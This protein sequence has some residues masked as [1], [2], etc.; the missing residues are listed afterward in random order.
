MN[1]LNKDQFIIILFR[2]KFTNGNY[3]TLTNLQK[4]NNSQEC[5]NDLL[6]LYQNTLDIKSEEYNSNE[7]I[8]IIFSY[9]II[10]QDKLINNKTKIDVKIKQMKVNNYKLYGYNLPTTMDYN[11]WGTITKKYDNII[12]IL[13]KIIVIYYI[14]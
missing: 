13:K 2:I 3:A 7:I 12:L 8:S 9:K 6:K 5:F 11:S 10:P 1:K 14:K 4:I